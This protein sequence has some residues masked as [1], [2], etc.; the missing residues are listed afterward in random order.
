[1]AGERYSSSD[2]CFDVFIG[3]MGMAKVMSY[4]TEYCSGINEQNLYILGA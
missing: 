4:L 2:I 3:T 1:M